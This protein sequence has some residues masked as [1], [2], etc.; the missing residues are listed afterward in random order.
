[1]ETLQN[2]EADGTTPRL[3]RCAVPPTEALDQRDLIVGRGSAPRRTS[4]G[5]VP[6]CAVE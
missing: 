3:F 6:A 1:M 5:V 4:R 2:S